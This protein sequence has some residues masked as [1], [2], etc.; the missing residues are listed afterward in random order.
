MFKLMSMFIL[1][2]V[3]LFTQ[4]SSACSVYVNQVHIQN[5]SAAKLANHF[6][7][8]LGLVRGIAFRN[9]QK[10]FVGSDPRTSCPYSLDT[11]VDV[12]LSYQN[13]RSTCHAIGQV[14][15]TENYF[16]RPGQPNVEF[17]INMPN[18]GCRII[19]P[20]MPPNPGPRPFPR[21][22]PG[23]RPIPRPGPRPTL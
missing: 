2:S 6:N 23:P 15:R 12:T 19:N 3:V 18:S 9:F 16:A 22:I 11:F 14:K 8:D 17:T 4:N 13:G 5:E 20:P 10:F 7:L 1:L 21:P